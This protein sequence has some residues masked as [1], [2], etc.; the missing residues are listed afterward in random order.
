M[1][2]HVCPVCGY[3]G[4]KRAAYDLPPSD[5]LASGSYEICESC[6]FQFGVTDDDR[7]KSFAQWRAQWVSRGMRW[8]GTKPRPVGWD[9]HMQLSRVNNALERFAVWNE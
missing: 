1:A 8:A 2:P 9:P 3:G 6:G 5:R 7:H 4:L